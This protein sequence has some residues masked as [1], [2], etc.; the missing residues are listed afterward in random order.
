MRNKCTRCS[1]VTT[2]V[3]CT[4]SSVDIHTVSTQ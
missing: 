4:I 1:G 2:H 3:C